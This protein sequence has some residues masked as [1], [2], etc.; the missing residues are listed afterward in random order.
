MPLQRLFSASLLFCLLVACGTPAPAATT[1]PSPAPTPT[2]LPSTLT[3]EPSPTPAPAPARARYTLNVLMDYAAKS[4]SVD[5]VILYPNHT[6]QA[7]TDLVLAVEAGL[8]PNCF[9]LNSLSVDGTAV[10]SYALDGQKLYFAL[11]NALQPEAT[12]TIQIQ[13]RILLPPLKQ[14][15]GVRP[16]IF[17]YSQLQMNLTDWYPFV[18]P[19]MNGGWVLH[20]PG[21]YGEH[22]V[23]EAA[24][25]SVNVKPADPAMK[26]IIASSGASSQNGEW[27]TY[28]LTAGRSFV[29]S[30]STDYLTSVV[31]VGNITVTSYYFQLYKDAAEAA[32]NSAAQALQIYSQR[33]G[34]YPHQTMAVVMGDFNDGMEFSALFFMPR[35][36]YNLYDGTVQNLTVDISAH[37]TSHQWWFEQVA[38]DQALQP[39]LDEALAAYSEHIFYETLYPQSVSWWWAYWLPRVGGS[40]AAPWLDTDIYSA[41]GFIPYTNGIY[42]QGAHFLDDLRARIGDESF[43]AFLQDY[44]AQENGRIATSADFFRILRLHTQADFTDLLDQYFQNGY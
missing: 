42:L 8:W 22:L 13:Y 5:E 40:Q 18:V 14:E 28:T 16:Q 21:Y 35:G 20:D 19:F 34:P 6:G 17:G 11:S 4:V 3:P 44:L 1:R 10:A 38:N 9:T 32:M 37:E 12:A 39:W 30:A 29:L 23:Y 24:D 26:L 27:T 36:V 15:H 25:Y 43:F 41:G 33:Y 7:L 31:Q 2:S